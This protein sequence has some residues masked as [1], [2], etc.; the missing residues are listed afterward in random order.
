MIG[1][2]ITCEEQIERSFGRKFC[3]GCMQQRA[4][5]KFRVANQ[6]RLGRHKIEYHCMVCDTPFFSTG[7]RK[8]QVCNLNRCQNYVKNLAKKMQVLQKRVETTHQKLVTVE[9]EYE[10]FVVRGL[11]S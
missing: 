3:E 10:S 11:V 4:K 9:N 7:K 2:C 5:I 1:Q 8:H 6:K